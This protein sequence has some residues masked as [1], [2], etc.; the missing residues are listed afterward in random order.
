MKDLKPCPFCSSRNVDAVFNAQLG[1]TFV[2]CWECGATASF[3]GREQQKQTVDAW[4]RR[5]QLAH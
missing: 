1:I 3:K 2:N 4:N 5:K